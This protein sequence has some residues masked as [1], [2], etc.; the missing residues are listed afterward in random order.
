MRVPV[1]PHPRQHSVLSVFWISAILIG[2]LWYQ[3]CIFKKSFPVIHMQMAQGFEKYGIYR[4]RNPYHLLAVSYMKVTRA[5][6]Q[7]V[8]TGTVTP[9]KILTYFQA[10]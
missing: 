9:V 6:T 1:A 7:L 10:P 4:K 2:V 8:L 3:S 5:D